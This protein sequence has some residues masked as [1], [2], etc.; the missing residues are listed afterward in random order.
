MRKL[1]AVLFVVCFCKCSCPKSES[2]V[3]ENVDSLQWI[4]MLTNEDA[5]YIS[6]QIPEGFFLD[7][8]QQFDNERKM[9]IFLVMPVFDIE[10]MEEIN[11][12]VKAGIEEQKNQFIAELGEVITGFVNEFYFVP[13]SIY[14]DEKIISYSFVMSCYH[15][16][17]VHPV[18]FYQSFNFDAKTKKSIDFEDYFILKTKTDSVFFTD[19]ITKSINREG[20]FLDTLYNL[21]FNIEKDT[22]SFDFSTYEIACYAAGLIQAKIHKKEL[23]GRIRANYR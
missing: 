10:D 5:I 14:Q 11:R 18:S 19:I 8:L 12:V 13:I 23:Y 20:V 22:I 7:T 6:V 3:T 17:A 1:I 9:G 21:D 4:S 16:G 2:I 15:A